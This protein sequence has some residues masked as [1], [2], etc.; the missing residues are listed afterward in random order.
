[1]NDQRVDMAFLVLNETFEQKR[2]LFVL[3]KYSMGDH[4]LQI[5]HTLESCHEPGILLVLSRPRSPE[6]LN[7]IHE[8]YNTEH[9]PARIQLGDEYFLNGYRYKAIDDDTTWLAIYD[10]R[11]LSAGSEKPY[12]TLRENR[13]LRE[14][15]VLRHKIENLSR[16]FLRLVRQTGTAEEPAENICVVTFNVSMEDANLVD[17]WYSQVRRTVKCYNQKPLADS[18][19]QIF[20]RMSTS[21]I[22]SRSRLFELVDGTSMAEDRS[23]FLAVHDFGE[24]PSMSVH[25]ESLRIDVE[26]SLSQN[27]AIPLGVRFFDYRHEFLA[28]NYRA[29]P[30][31]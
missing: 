3:D 27:G 26:E 25:E 2:L 8:W 31:Q 9:G 11:R 16:Q 10:M 24:G 19:K 6:Y 12:T 21:Y 7:D 4:K 23:H 28:S 20:D 5:P 1:M 29:P 22:C 17:S 13:S 30:E 15:Q 18:A 14:Q